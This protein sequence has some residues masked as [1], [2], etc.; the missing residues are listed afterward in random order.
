MRFAILG[1]GGIGALRAQTI[2]S[3]PETELVAIADVDETRARAAAGGAAVYS[4]YR[5]SLGHAGVEAVVVCSPVQLHEAMCVAAFDAGFDVLCEKPLSNSLESCRRILAAAERT[6]RTLAVGFNHRYYPFMK[7]IKRAVDDGR[8]GKLDE[9]R[10]FGGHCEMYRF[11]SEWMWKG[12]VSGGGAMMDVGIHVTDLGRYLL[13]E[14]TDVYGVVG[15]NVWNVPGSEDRAQAIFRTE[16]GLSASYEATWNEWKGYS[17]VV[18]AYGDRGMVR[19]S[20]APMSNMLITF[21]DPKGPKRV[22]RERYLGAILREKVKGWQT[23]TLLTFDD[24]LADFLRMLDGKS[25]PLADGW[26]GLRAIEIAQA[27]YESSRTGQAVQ[28]S[29]RPGR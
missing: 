17:V 1:A 6:G 26:S 21:D 25:V 8:I 10:L 14:V 11:H 28:L 5:D 2:H 3:H 12:D 15:S 19:G 20:Y 13:G 29:E 4:D 23:T 9:V 18:E 27:V 24:E 16:S 7:Y 22:E